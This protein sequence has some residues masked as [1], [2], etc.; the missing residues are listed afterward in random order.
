MQAIQSKIPK[1]TLRTTK[2]AYDIWNSW[3]KIRNISDEFTQMTA[4]RM[5]ELLAQFIME[6]R[7]QDSEV[8]PSKTC[9]K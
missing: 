5:D 8:Y 7:R 1:K 9:S 6:T 3:C 4:S 2:W